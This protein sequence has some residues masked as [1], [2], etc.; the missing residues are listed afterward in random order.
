MGVGH[1]SSLD[2][3]AWHVEQ[4]EFLETGTAET[5]ITEVG[6]LDYRAVYLMAQDDVVM[7]ETI[8][9]VPSSAVVS[10]IVGGT[11]S[12]G[13]EAVGLDPADVGGAGPVECV[14]MDAQVKVGLGLGGCRWPVL[15]FDEGVRA[16]DE[17]DA[18]AGTFESATDLSRE[19]QRIVFFLPTAFGVAGILA[20]VASVQCDGPDRLAGRSAGRG[21]EWIEERF[22]IALR[23][24]EPFAHLADGE[25]QP[26]VG[27]VEEDLLGVRLEDQFLGLGVELEF[28][29][30]SG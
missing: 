30:A 8:P 25:G 2:E 11:G 24:L 28:V 4:G 17:D 15:Q 5:A 19:Q 22:E 23:D 12:G 27:L 10:G 20:A 13:G 14:E 21:E 16:A 7:V 29:T 18:E 9:G 26:D 3:D 6:A 1:V